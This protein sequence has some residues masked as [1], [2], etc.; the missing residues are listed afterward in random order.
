MKFC[1]KLNKEFACCN[2]I[3][4]LS[5]GNPMRE[6]ALLS[7]KFEEIKLFSCIQEINDMANSSRNVLL[8][9]YFERNKYFDFLIWN[10]MEKNLYVFQTAINKEF[11]KS[12]ELF[13][14][15]DNLN[16]YD[17]ITENQIKFFWITLKEID[18][19]NIMRE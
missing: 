16:Q 5:N 14:D 8:K 4:K 2:M 17:H 19:S 3:K 15:K 11:K 7:I 1:S 13:F 12:D 10:G 9:P 6:E 18:L